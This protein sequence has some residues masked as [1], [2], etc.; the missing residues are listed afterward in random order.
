M[1]QFDLAKISIDTSLNIF[2]GYGLGSPTL[3]IS[4]VYLRVAFPGILAPLGPGLAKPASPY[5][6][7]AGIIKV[8]LDK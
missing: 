4:T 7:S 1:C 2:L 8:A 6:S 3:A 5:A